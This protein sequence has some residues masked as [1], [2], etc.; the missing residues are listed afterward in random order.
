MLLYSGMPHLPPSCQV[1]S[2]LCHE[3]ASIPPCTLA[4]VVTSIS[5][6]IQTKTLLSRTRVCAD[7]A[8]LVGHH[9][10]V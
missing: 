8:A 10:Q 7:L 6:R 3:A 5:H 9:R 1:L 4:L 2:V